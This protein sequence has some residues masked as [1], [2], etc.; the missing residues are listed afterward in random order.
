LLPIVALAMT[1]MVVHVLEPAE[2][3]AK[4]SETINP[5]IFM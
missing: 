2:S 5:Q 3:E 1:S 4:Q